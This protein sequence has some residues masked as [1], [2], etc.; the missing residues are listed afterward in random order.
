MSP[1]SDKKFTF[2]VDDEPIPT[3]EHELTAAEILRLAERDPDDF[4]LRR[5][6]GGPKATLADSA[7]VKIN[8][9]LAFVT[10]STRP[11]PVK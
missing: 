4:D 9:G 11:T 6:R 2:E 5:I 10:V 1:K 8:S 3:D 7:V